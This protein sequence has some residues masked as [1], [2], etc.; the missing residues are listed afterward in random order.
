MNIRWFMKNPL[1][2]ITVEELIPY[3]R[4]IA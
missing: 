4:Y 2:K 3:K 1:G